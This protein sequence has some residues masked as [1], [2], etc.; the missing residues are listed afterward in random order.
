ML[1]D[2]HIH[3]AAHGEFSYSKDRVTAYMQKAV[4]RG[5]TALGFCEHDEWAGRVDRALLDEISAEYPEMD[6][7]V[8]LEVD[9][10]PGR[11]TE[12]KYLLAE[13]PLDYVIGSVHF[14]DGWNFDHPDMRYLFEQQDIDRVYQ[15]YF[16]L[17]NQAVK[18][19]LFDVAG[20]LDLIKIWGHRPRDK[21]VLYY[22]EPVL[23]SIKRAGMAIEINTA[24]LRK[25]AAE[26]YPSPE[27]IEL[28]FR[29]GIPV[30]L[31]SDA[32]TPEQVGENLAETAALLS[33]I[34]FKSIVKFKKR[35][36]LAIAL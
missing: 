19:G 25:D 27:I 10:I 33:R 15:Q 26:I 34:G 2:Y 1:A 5:I 31:G 21:K 4:Q 7:A 8:G 13:Q 17:V 29:M 11:E 6:I 22:V 14:I 12:I 23:D 18:S 3:I 16:T 20:H 9:F 32:H 24:G 30:T 36:A 35:Q 28:V